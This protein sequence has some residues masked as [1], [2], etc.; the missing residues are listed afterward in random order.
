MR[1]LAFLFLAGCNA[2]GG[3]TAY[4]QLD[5][6]ARLAGLS[7]E[8]AGWRGAPLLPLELRVG[9][10]AM[11]LGAGAPRPLALEAGRLL[12]VRGA[13]GVIEGGEPDPDRLIVGG[14][15]DAVRGLADL[16]S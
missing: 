4:V 13:D 14:E 10:E 16:L 6:D 1:M 8:L 2:V 12:R 7:V 5:R 3:A 15:P 11:L 9:E